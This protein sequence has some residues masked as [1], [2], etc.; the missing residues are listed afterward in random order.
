MKI[1]KNYMLTL[2]LIL[3]INVVN[4]SSLSDRIKEVSNEY[5]SNNFLNATFMFADDNQI[6]F[7]GVKGLY[8]LK[9]DQLIGNQNMPIA[10]GT[11]PMVAVAILKLQDMGLL[12]I[13][14]TLD[15]LIDPSL[16]PDTKPI[17]SDKITLH[18]LLTHTSGLPE[19]LAKVQFT[20]DE[21]HIH[22][23]K[24]AFIE[25]LS[26][27]PLQGKIAPYSTKLQTN[28]DKNHYY[29]YTNS[30]YVLLG[31]VVEHIGKKPLSEFLKEYIFTPLNM[32][33]THVSTIRD[34]ENIIEKN[35]GNYNYPVRYFVVP[36]G[37][38]PKFIALKSDFI[39]VPFGDGSIISNRED[40]IKFH[41][42]L[43]HKKLLSE[44]SYNMMIKKYYKVDKNIFSIFKESYTGYG[45][46]TTILNTKHY[47]LEHAGNAYGVRS[48][49]GYI[50][51]K[52]LYF[53]IISNV[54]QIPNKDIPDLDLTNS[55][56][57]LDIIFF[58]DKILQSI[59]SE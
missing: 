5:I 21:K 16:W 56:N 35:S 25:F 41:K 13:T 6:L 43:H 15:K 1:F 33:N 49:S 47:M 44:K 46:F 40:L 36:T 54:M 32:N 14:D 58:K 29:K 59:I 18:N 45:I 20:L 39:V 2:L 24:K 4:A 37:E 27:N 7:N 50:P 12:K 19:Y 31:L 11:K 55:V 26:N 10:S 22:N 30:N 38:K 3:N 57:H 51:T 8:N 42:A 48:E 34:T 53:A 23:N 17:W 9:G 28:N 52:G